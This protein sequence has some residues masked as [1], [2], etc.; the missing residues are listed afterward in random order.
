MDEIEFRLEDRFQWA[1]DPLQCC[2]GLPIIPQYNFRPLAEAIEPYPDVLYTVDE[3][4][5]IFFE[6]AK[7]YTACGANH[8][9]KYAVMRKGNASGWKKAIDAVTTKIKNSTDEVNDEVVEPLVPLI[10]DEST[11]ESTGED[12]GTG[13]TGEDGGTG[14]TGGSIDPELTVI[15]CDESFNK[16]GGKGTSSF[17]IDFGNA[18]GECGINFNAAAIPDRFKII[19]NGSL[20]A[21]S[22]FVGSEDS[23]ADLLALGYEPEELNLGVGGSGTLRF[24]KDSSIPTQAIVEVDAPFD[25]TYW[26]IDGVCVE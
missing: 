7:K 25:S 8:N 2:A 15:G 23:E 6:I 24:I 4:V 1:Q 12:G 22:K 3:I 5:E 20:V 19:W 16:S 26:A 13:G 21:D 11:D 9:D 18:V 14:G 17:V 10:P